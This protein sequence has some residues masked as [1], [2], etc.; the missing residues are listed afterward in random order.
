MGYFPNMTSWEM[1]AVDNCNR[2]AHAPQ[3]EEA[4]ACPVDLVHTLYNYDFCNEKDHPAKVMLDM[5]IPVHKSGCKNKRC[6]MFQPRNGV[7]DKHLKDWSKYKAI[8]AEMSS[9]LAKASPEG[10][11]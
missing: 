9:P 2:C 6:A 11:R 3:T 4:D 7:T 5:L 10:G 8:M 1:W